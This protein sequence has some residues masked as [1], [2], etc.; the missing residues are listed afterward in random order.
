M[1]RRFFII[2]SIFLS[3][4]F[5]FTLFFNEPDSVKSFLEQI[6]NTEVGKV[7]EVM[8]HPAKGEKAEDWRVKDLNLLT[9]EKVID[10]FSSNDIELISY[11]QLK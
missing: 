9:S 7:T 3:S 11:G 4:L 5:L 10:Y 8:F 2:L 6:N 1:K